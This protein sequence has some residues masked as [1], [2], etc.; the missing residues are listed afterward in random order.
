MSA[1]SKALPNAA[2]S[3]QTRLEEPAEQVAGVQA[4][5]DRVLVDSSVIRFGSPRHP[6]IYS[7]DLICIDRTHSKSKKEELLDGEHHTA[8]LRAVRSHLVPSV[9]WKV[10]R[11]QYPRRP[12]FQR[13]IYRRNT[14]RRLGYTA[15][16][17]LPG[18]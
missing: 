5:H 15:A 10:G 17:Q 2:I 8:L 4:L 13:S 16:L 1:L 3:N 7:H 6:D 12:P 18:A 9:V 14:A 11:L